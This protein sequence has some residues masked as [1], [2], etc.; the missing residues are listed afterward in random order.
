MLLMLN[1]L[2]RQNLV[3][4]DRRLSAGSSGNGYDGS[5]HSSV[6]PT[7]KARELVAR[8]KPWVLQCGFAMA[9]L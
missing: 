9:G 7:T 6:L 4:I 8:Y 1:G 2:K 3:S 5:L